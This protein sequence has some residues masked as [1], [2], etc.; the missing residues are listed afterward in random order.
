MQQ[1]KRDAEEEEKEAV[2]LAAHAAMLI[3]PHTP[4]LEAFLGTEEERKRDD[5]GA[6]L[7][8]QIQVCSP[9]IAAGLKVIEAQ[10]KLPLN[11][12]DALGPC[13]TICGYAVCGLNILCQTT[14][15][16]LLAKINSDRMFNN[17]PVLACAKFT[18]KGIDVCGNATCPNPE[19]FWQS[20][21][22]CLPPKRVHNPSKQDTNDCCQRCD[23]KCNG[24]RCP[25]VTCPEPEY[26]LCTAYQ[27]S[28]YDQFDCCQ[29][30]IDPCLGKKAACAAPP[31]SCP[32]GQALGPAFIGDCCLSCQPACAGVS[33]SG[34]P[35]SAKDCPAGQVWQDRPATPTRCGDCCPKCVAKDNVD[36][37]MT[38]AGVRAF[39]LAVASVAVAFV[40]ML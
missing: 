11:I 24:V 31:S 4:G 16:P 23:D 26:P 32:A 39:A 25:A 8:S 10:V 19:G 40:A 35:N 33:C 34:A 9:L 29:Q 36:K 38:G 28:K 22:N 2:R 20:N 18:P 12:S 21:T 27:V 15:A 5:I 1:K 3:A 7:L 30:C 37:I 6:T 14:A 13:G 17:C